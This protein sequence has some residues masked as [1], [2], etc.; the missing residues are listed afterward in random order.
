V[1]VT[2]E[3]ST[4]HA[5]AIII[6]ESGILIRG[7]AGSGKSSVARELIARAENLG[8]HAAL[9]ADD[10]VLLHRAGGRLIASTVSPVA[11]L[12]EIRG[13]GIVRVPHEPA[14]VLRLIVDLA[15]EP[16]RVPDDDAIKASVEGV[17]LPK[18]TV[19]PALGAGVVLWTLGQLHDAFMTVS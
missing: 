18:I 16:P 6:G 11:G 10:R 2:A 9:V 17:P 5:T 8:R 12:L 4:V 7:E 3:G 19:N 14:A 1:S 13:I 15:D